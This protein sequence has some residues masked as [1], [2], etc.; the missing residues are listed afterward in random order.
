MRRSRRRCCRRLVRE[1]ADASFNRI[2]ID[3]DTSTN[4]SF[5]LI[6]THQAGNAPITQLEQR[7]RCA[8]A[9]G[10]DRRVAAAG[11]GHRARRRR[12]DQVHHRAGRRR[13]RRR[14]N[15]ARWPTPSRH[16]PL[17]KTAFFA[18]DPNLGRILAAVGY[19]GIDDLDQGLIDLFLDDVHVAMHGG[20]PPGLRRRGRPARD[21]A[22]RDHG[23]GATCTAARPTPRCGPAICRTTTSASTPTT[24]VR[25]CWR[26]RC[27]KLR[28]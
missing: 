10:G 20:A 26:L 2:T 22:K 18:S 17:V 24:A 16:S 21:E 23:A 14:T 27:I 4:D 9:R 28:C 15:A 8:A 7:R 6:A 12:C 25:G 1:A 19:A 13:A 3:G 5:V 11:A